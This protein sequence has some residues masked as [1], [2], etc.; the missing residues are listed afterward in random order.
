M[1]PASVKCA[2]T[3]PGRDAC[4]M[5]G[6]NQCRYEKSGQCKCVSDEQVTQGTVDIKTVAP[7]NAY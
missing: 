2:L 4:Q 1:C 7:D 5:L 6:L 3:S